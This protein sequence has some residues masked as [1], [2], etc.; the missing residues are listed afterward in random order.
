MLD[1]NNKTLLSDTLQRYFFHPESISHKDL[2]VDVEGIAGTLFTQ[3]QSKLSS[4]STTMNSS[5]SIDLTDSTHNPSSDSSSAII[6][7]SGGGYRSQLIAAMLA[8]HGYTTLQLSYFNHEGLPKTYKHLD[9]K[10][11]EKSLQYLKS[12][13]YVKRFGVF[14]DSKSGSLAQMMN[15]FLR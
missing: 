8:S 1:Q 4:M 2:S 12:L 9:I 3:T 5:S 10:Y 15:A 13:G 7:M 14:G 6:T 11:F